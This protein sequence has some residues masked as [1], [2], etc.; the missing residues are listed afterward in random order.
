[1]FF[2]E[3]LYVRIIW[4]IKMS[5]KKFQLENEMKWVN[6]N[7]KFLNLC[8]SFQYILEQLKKLECRWK[9]NVKICSLIFEIIKEIYLNKNL[10]IIHI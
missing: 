8:F 3:L 9:S 1:M 5:S 4:M 6:K 10:R 7:I 2:F